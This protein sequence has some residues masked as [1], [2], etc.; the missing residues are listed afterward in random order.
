MLRTVSFHLILL[1]DTCLLLSK[2]IAFRELCVMGP[3]L[4]EFLLLGEYGCCCIEAVG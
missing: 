4:N 3:L 2:M 1:V